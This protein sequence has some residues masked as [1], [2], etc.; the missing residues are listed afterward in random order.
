MFL[1]AARILAEMVDD[2]ALATGS[3]YPPLAN[4]RKVSLAIAV[5]I[6]EKA[7]EQGLAEEERPADVE[8]MIAE[9]MYVPE[10]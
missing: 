5:A 9:Q 7:W 10:Y 4:I 6:A 1:E 3:L 8:S 2:N